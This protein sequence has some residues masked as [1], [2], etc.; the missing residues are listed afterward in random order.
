MDIEIPF[1]LRSAALSRQTEEQ[2]AFT[3]N[4]MTIPVQ[5][6]LIN[7]KSRNILLCIPI[8]AAVN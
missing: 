6:T 5:V 4:V 3:E 1:R 2:I 8:E 7:L